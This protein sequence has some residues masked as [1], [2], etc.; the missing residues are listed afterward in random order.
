MK[1]HNESGPYYASSELEK[2]MSTDTLLEE[3]LTKDLSD[4]AEQIHFTPAMRA[5]VLYAVSQQ[6]R[7]TSANKRRLWAPIVA[8][9]VVLLLA[10]VLAPPLL[11]VFQPA[12]Q[13]VA[14]KLSTQRAV[15]AELANGGQLLSVDPTE[16]YLV[17]QPSNQPG[18]L[19]TADVA[20]P[21]GSNLL[22]MRYARDM[23]WAPDGSALVAT[24]VPE[25][26]KTPL[27]ALVPH[28]EYMHLIGPAALAVSWSPNGQ[29]LITYASQA[30]GRTQLWSIHPDGSE[31]KLLAT[32]NIADPVQH[33]IWSP[34][35]Q[36]LA[37]VVDNFSSTQASSQQRAIFLVDMQSQNLQE[38][39]KAGSFTIGNVGWSP[40]SRY[41]TYEQTAINGALTL[42]GV[43]RTDQGHTFSIAIQHQLAGWSWSSNSNALVY[44][45]GGKLKA[46]VLTGAQIT[47]PAPENSHTSQTTPF[48]LKDG[49]ILFIQT[50][51]NVEKLSFMQKQQ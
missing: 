6:R 49:R 41:L 36:H 38:I 28:G 30:D 20:N 10:I 17:Y 50:T 14:Y 37:I 18:V 4:L 22:A 15:P 29:K 23:A 27:L 33:L 25:G 43:D 39:V 45:D 42:H 11:H 21:Q 9:A 13:V 47:F 2:K 16:H 8:I 1:H 35:G 40:D 3:R 24:V 32:V 48:W 19:Y 5:R 46:H 31:Q 26:T 34:D 51:D 7:H 44:S 12:G